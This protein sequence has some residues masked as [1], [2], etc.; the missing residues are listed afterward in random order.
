MKTE[1]GTGPR[2]E[3]D[4]NIQRAAD[5]LNDVGFTHAYNRMYR[6]YC[7]QP[8]A[9]LAMLLT[10]LMLRMVEDRNNLCT[11]TN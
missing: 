1:L 3:Q 4:R 10:Q 8:R 7:K 5:L 11:K 2:E 9:D 6:Y